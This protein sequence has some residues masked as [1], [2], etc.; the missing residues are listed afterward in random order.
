MGYDSEQRE[1][2][3]WSLSPG[4]SD[5]MRQKEAPLSQ[6]LLSDEEDS[7]P[8]SRS[9]CFACR[10]HS[11]SS[12]QCPS[13]ATSPWPRVPRGRG[14]ECGHP[15]LGMPGVGRAELFWDCLHLESSWSLVPEKHPHVGN[16]SELFTV[17]VFLHLLQL[18]LLLGWKKNLLV[19][20]HNLW[21]SAFD[22]PTEKRETKRLREGPMGRCCWEGN[23]VHS[24]D[25]PGW[26]MVHSPLSAKGQSLPGPWLF[27]SNPSSQFHWGAQA[28]A[29]IRRRSGPGRAS[30]TERRRERCQ[31]QR[32]SAQWGP[33][34][35]GLQQ[36][37]R[38]AH[39]W[40]EAQAMTIPSLLGQ[41]YDPWE[42]L[43]HVWAPGDPRVWMGLL[44]FLWEG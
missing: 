42:V 10:P 40:V 39:C 14:R 8:A 7:I 5:L 4:R 13:P 43:L 38:V 37:S 26:G 18:F 3:S 32:M 21:G 34:G 30:Q 44:L 31:A 22:S 24:I 28:R 11:N 35:H 33:C 17:G 2:L 36:Q 27:P 20:S 15:V 23:V 41:P 12:A 25:L 19:I 29:C 6:R 9:L 16:S 1:P